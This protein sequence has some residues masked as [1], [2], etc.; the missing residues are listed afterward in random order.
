MNTT[1]TTLITTLAF[2]SL[3]SAT[4]SITYNGSTG[5]DILSNGTSVGTYTLDTGG[6]THTFDAATGI[7]DFAGT[8][9]ASTDVTIAFTFTDAAFTLGSTRFAADGDPAFNFGNNG[10]VGDQPFSASFNVDGTL[11]VDETGDDRISFDNDGN[12]ITNLNHEFELDGVA[13]DTSA[14]GGVATIAYTADSVLREVNPINSQNALNTFDDLYVFESS[15]L[16]QTLTYNSD[17][18]NIAAEGFVLSFDVV[19][20][21][22]STA[23]LG[24]GSLALLLRRRR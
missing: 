9:N 10:G 1:I 3:A 13:I 18:L 4:I 24:L 12:P 11:T 15:E 20:E 6:I 16:S 21:P 8:I 14:T 2:T 23:L 17:D 22:S 19:P 7:F 5:G